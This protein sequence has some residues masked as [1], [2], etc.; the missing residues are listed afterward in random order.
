VEYVRNTFAIQYGTNS[1]AAEVAEIAKRSWDHSEKLFN[2]TF[3]EFG[4]AEVIS[5]DGSEETGVFRFDMVRVD[6]VIAAIAYALFFLEKRQQWFGSFEV[7]CGFHS[8]RSLQGFPD[9]TEARGKW[10]SSLPYLQRTTP[11]PDVFKYGM[12]ENDELVFALNFYERLWVYAR[13]TGQVLVAA[14]RPVLIGVG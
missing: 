1:A 12:Y 8:E 3:R 4:V 5:D 6:R 7:F 11:Y 9:G 10:F 14:A 13:R 2:R